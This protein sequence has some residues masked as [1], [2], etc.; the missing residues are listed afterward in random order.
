MIGDHIRALRDGRWSHGID[1]G[2]RTVIHVEVG[3]APGS[4]VQ[5]SYRP[6]FEAGAAAVEVVLHRER[7]YAPKAVVARAFAPIRDPALAAMFGDSEDF[8]CWCKAGRLPERPRKA[9]PIEPAAAAKAVVA[10][11]RA[12][13]AK[14]KPKKPS[15]ARR[16]EARKGAPRK[17][18]GPKKAGRRPI[19]KKAARK[20]P[21]RRGR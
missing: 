11:R 14:A 2:D 21:K 5:R 20:S 1:C 19:A 16:G 12:A 17:A 6:T 4:R 8:A 3:A 18:A 7:V 10:R 13:A 9:V 15:A